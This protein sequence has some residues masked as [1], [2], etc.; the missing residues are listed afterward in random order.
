MDSPIK[1]SLFA[2]CLV[3]QLF[4]E[5]GVSV[6]RVLRRLGVEIDFPNDQT[7]CGQPLFNAGFTREAKSLALRVIES[8]FNQSQDSDSHYLVVPSG[9]CAAM[10]R[11]FYPSLFRENPEML[12]RATELGGRVFEFSEFLTKVLDVTD[13]GAS[14]QGENGRKVTYHPSCHLLRELGISQG[15]QELLASVKGCDEVE[16]DQAETCCGFGGAFS[17]KY[18]DISA[19]M[20]KDKIDNIVRAGADTLVACDMGCLMQISGGL[21]RRGH[22]IKTMHLAQVLEGQV[23]K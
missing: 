5:V 11:V 16:L 13:V 23:T 9:S 6:V 4:P 1:V 20:L 12:E 2:T 21:N 18:P 17:V 7:C 3:D 19:A 15:P 14:F 22:N 10:I 8:F